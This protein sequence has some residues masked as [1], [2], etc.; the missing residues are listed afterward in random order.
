[1]LSPLNIFLFLE[2]TD[3]A[4]IIPTVV[5]VIV[6]Y[7]IVIYQVYHD[8]IIAVA[9]AGISTAIAGIYATADLREPTFAPLWSETCGRLS[10]GL[11]CI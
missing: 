1:M 8:V 7:V 9:I 3:I 5:V 6:G 4:L 2:L 10:T 11:T